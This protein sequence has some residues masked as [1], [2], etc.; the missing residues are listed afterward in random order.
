MSIKEISNEIKILTPNKVVE[1]C[2]TIQMTLSCKYQI[3]GWYISI[4]KY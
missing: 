3:G 1:K 4:L 2:M